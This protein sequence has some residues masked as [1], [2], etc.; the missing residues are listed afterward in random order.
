MRGPSG[1]LPLLLEDGDAV[2]LA[3]ADSDMDD[4]AVGIPMGELMLS[5]PRLCDGGGVRI[6]WLIGPTTRFDPR[7]PSPEKKDDLALLCNAFGGDF[8]P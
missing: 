3:S 1:R 6:G 2:T 7:R 4:E 5:G 8:G